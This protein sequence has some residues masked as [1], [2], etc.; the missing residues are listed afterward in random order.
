M[1]IDP[2]VPRT[3][4]ALLAAGLGGVAAVVA[5]AL[6]RPAPT[7][8]AN[9]DPVLAG[10]ANTATAATSIS[11]T[12]GGTGLLAVSGPDVVAPAAKIGLYGYANQDSNARAVYGKSLVGTGVWGNSDTGR[13]LFGRSTS[14]TG[15]SAQ[16][17]TGRA[18]YGTSAA[19]DKTAILG[20]SVGN[21]TGVQGFSGNVPP[22]PEPETGVHGAAS[23]STSSNGVFGFSGAG[24]GV[25]GDTDSGLGVIG[26]A[27]GD[28]LGNGV[29]VYGAGP[30]GVYAYAPDNGYALVADGPS[31]FSQSGVVTIASGSSV[32]VAVGGGL[33]ADSMVLA[34]L[35]TNRTGVWVRAVAPNSATGQATIYL[36]TSVGASTKIAW[37]VVG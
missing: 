37:F 12:G 4:R 5:S 32:V 29:G 21:S 30:I 22:A 3:R 7:R 8:A 35:Q 24:A 17:D 1:A 28:D 2:I 9:G 33:R 18:V 36:N 20:Q 15:V 34:M 6:G 31:F 13:G 16:T 27:T 23:L 25:W 10:Q 19:S 14:G 26:S 11:N